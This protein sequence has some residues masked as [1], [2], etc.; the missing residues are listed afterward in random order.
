MSPQRSITTCLAKYV[1]FSG[2][3][4]LSEYWWF[5]LFVTLG[6]MIAGALDSALFGTGD[7]M[8]SHYQPG[9]LQPVF[10]LAVL[11]PSL[12]VAWRRLHDSGRPGWYILIP[13]VVLTALAAVTLFG[14]M[15]F[16]NTQNSYSMMR[17]IGG[18]M[19][20]G[21][22]LLSLLAVTIALAVCV[23]WLTRPSQPI[24]NQY[25]PQPTQQPAH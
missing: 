12:A 16:L 9:I 7:I 25:G 24:P 21:L 1:Q 5:T 4:P 20:V 19:A 17:G 2:R 15:G 11:L 3:A 14:T 18:L 22:S 8:T 6:V 23:Y 13:A 10:Q